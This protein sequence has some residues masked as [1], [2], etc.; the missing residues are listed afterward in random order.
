MFLF[1][2]YLDKDGKF[3]NYN[4]KNFDGINPFDTSKSELSFYTQFLTD[5][6]YMKDTKNLSHNIV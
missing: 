2:N 3:F 1:E 4:T 6:D 5:P